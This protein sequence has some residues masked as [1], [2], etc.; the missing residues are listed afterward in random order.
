MK[1][2]ARLEAIVEGKV[3][4]FMLD[5]D[6]NIAAAKEMLFQFG[7]YLAQIEANVKAQQEAQKAEADAKA[8]QPPE[9][10]VEAPKE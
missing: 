1:T 9:A 3:G 5:H 4:H 8:S 6:T 7:A 2:I 10:P